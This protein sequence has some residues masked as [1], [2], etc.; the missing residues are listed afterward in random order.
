MRRG[1]R[2]SIDAGFGVGLGYFPNGLDIL[3]MGDQP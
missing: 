3:E 2:G 1:D